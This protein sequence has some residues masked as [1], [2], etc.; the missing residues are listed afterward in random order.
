VAQHLQTRG[1]QAGGDPDFQRA[2]AALARGDLQTAERGL[3]KLIRRG[4]GNAHVYNNLGALLAKRGELTDALQMFE[5]ALTR[6]AALASARENLIQA[7][8]TR[9][10]GHYRRGELAEAEADL[11]AAL[12]LNPTSGV[13]ASDLGA[14]LAAGGRFPEAIEL[15]CQAVEK[16]PELPVG[17]TN[18]GTAMVA[19]G[20]IPEACQVLE[21]ALRI[22]PDNVTALINL[23][24]VMETLGRLGR[25]ETLARR[26]I[27]IDPRSAVA[28]NNLGTALLQQGDLEGT[29]AHYHQACVL[30]PER[31]D[32]FS[33]YLFTLNNDPRL[34]PEEI[35]A[36]HRQFD[37]KYGPEQ[38]RPRV[39]RVRPEGRRLRVGYLSPDFRSHSVAYF[40][41]PLLGA[42]DQR[43][44]EITCYSDAAVNDGVTKR[45]RAQAEHWRQVA[46][47]SDAAI[48]RIV[49]E[50]GIDVLV[51]LAG[52]TASNRMRL[53]A[54]RAAPVQFTYLGYPASS[55]LAAMD[56]RL[57]DAVADPVGAEAVHT[58]ELARLEGGFLCYRPPFGTGEGPQ[59]APP[60]SAS[61]APVTFGSFNSLI[62]A[63]D[64][65]L[66]AWARLL[67][68]VPGSRL[69]LKARAMS[70]EV[71][72]E[73][74][75]RKM[76]ER[77]IARAR[78]ELA[79]PAPRIDDHLAIY[80]RIDIALD[81]F[82]YNGTTTTCEALWMGVPLVTFAGPVHS[83]RVGS[84]ILT[85][86]GLE[87]LSAPTL[88]A[89]LDIAATL[90][91][92]TDRLVSLR[93]SM[94]DRM[95]CSPLMDA[96]RLAREIEAAYH[97][98]FD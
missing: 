80:G 45:L 91:A 34:R 42:H 89:S 69:L 40:F 38:P 43:A 2:V 47:L 82:P 7:R 12:A 18:L 15:Y 3:R 57:T 27:E 60:P 50:D 70:E 79:P 46:G 94:R 44:V 16:A 56:Y 55:G 1:A 31:A 25:A 92:D 22:A 96:P 5:A 81:T 23:A 9:G 49:E 68:R 41:D 20:K 84:S 88:E 28:H 30:A 76:E 85:R 51:D 14:V 61:G 67:Q 97:Q 24:G 73:R 10:I 93:H 74:L 4:T 95:S 19:L 66:D 58:E 6:D 78:V 90:A 35:F 83:S 26:A 63:N 11:R 64:A 62:K 71:V 36:Q 53:F 39:R 48:A 37:A 8:A 21:Q 65:V 52:H 75:W 54:R 87:E 86:I 17:Y 32:C 59:V 29:L 33:S 72:Q 13:L 77:G 98:A